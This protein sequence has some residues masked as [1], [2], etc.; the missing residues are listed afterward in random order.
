MVD[1]G[2]TL[3]DTKL[4]SSVPIVQPVADKSSEYLASGIKSGIEGAGNFLALDAKNKAGAAV[5]A[6][7]QDIVEKMSLLA[8][9]REQ[10]KLTLAQANRQL[11]VWSN[12][13]VSNFPDQ[14]D[15][16]FQLTAKL[17]GDR[18]IAGSIYTESDAERRD[19]ELMDEGAKNGWDV[20][21]VEGQT[22]WKAF[23]NNTR[24]LDI[25]AQQ[26]LA[27]QQSNQIATEGQKSSYSQLFQ[28]TAASAYPWAIDK[29]NTANGLLQGVADP[30]QRQQVI[31]QLKNE[32]AVETGKLSTYG[33]LAG[34]DKVDY[35]IKPINDLIAQFELTASGKST[36]QALET[37]IARSKA[38]QE[39]LMFSDPESGKLFLTNAV[40]QFTDPYAIAQLDAAKLKFAAGINVTPTRAD[41]GTLTY[42]QKP[43]DVVDKVEN[44]AAVLELDRKT[45]AS[46]LGSQDVPA[47]ATQ[48]MND[49]IA[50]VLYST[51]KNGAN[52][53]DATNFNAV[54]NYLADTS[55]GQYMEQNYTGIGPKIA[56]S[57]A[58]TVE[59]QYSDVVLELVNKRWL[60]AGAQ[61]QTSGQGTKGFAESI[62]AVGNQ[63][64]GTES[65]L[66]LSKLIEPV[67]NGYGIE[68]RVKDE[69]K[70]DPNLAGVAKSLNQGKDSVAG[71]VNKMIRMAAHLA[72]TTDYEKIYNENFKSRL[73]VT[74]DQQATGKVDSNENLDSVSNIPEAAL[75]G[76]LE[77]PKPPSGFSETP[78]ARRGQTGQLLDA[79]GSAEGANY[80]TLFGYAE[81]KGPFAGTQVTDM[82]I[83]EVQA[84]QKLMVK[85]N[86][87]SSAVGK[88][89]V[90]SD[91]LKEAVQAL[92]LSEDTKFTPEV[93]DKI[94]LYLLQSRTNFGDWVAGAGDPAEFQN[95]LAKIW[96]SIPD[97]TGRS[98]YAGDGVN[99]ASSAGTKLAGLL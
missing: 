60:E 91:T 88:Y 67:W 16:I 61:V 69:Y 37:S 73:W 26:L 6:L 7:Q 86:G 28:K 76:G 20:S 27:L 5:S 53:E 39:V 59:R 30:V 66:D 51:W 65:M 46:M 41:D 85:N 84:L 31:D 90:L 47:E 58:Y 87:I 32:V 78:S 14:A 9:G 15:T 1:F 82:T 98:Y 40:S 72:G 77:R 74:G 68:F 4:D 50:T 97:T 36:Q 29:I 57:A 92:G 11:R 12:E 63:Q 75:K 43:T 10:G 48:A 62:G 33:S 93:Q 81:Q 42:D 55:V 89:Q 70:N 49:K 38:Q 22:N 17:G 34:S 2:D 95:G 83:G 71:P 52:E 24:Q 80:D 8:D 13:W 3:F 44:M 94:A 79:I 19:R 18:G 23:K 21:T 99:S 45:V 56:Q 54:V 35:L 64:V 96:A 25:Q